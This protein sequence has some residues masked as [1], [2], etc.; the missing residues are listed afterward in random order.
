[1][2]EGRYLELVP[3]AETA[4][5]YVWRNNTFEGFWKSVNNAALVIAKT[6]EQAAFLLNAEL[7]RR[8]LPGDVKPEGMV[9]TL[10][11]EERVIILHDGDY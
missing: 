10:P 1:M 7:R 11:N 2:I 4:T 5:R 8:D 3:S 6:Q 9:L